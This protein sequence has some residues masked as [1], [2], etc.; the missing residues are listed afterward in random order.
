M[1][2]KLFVLVLC[3]AALSISAQEPERKS[4][5]IV[6]SLTA[7]EKTDRN[8]VLLRSELDSLVQLHGNK[9]LVVQPQENPVEP[10]SMD[11]VYL[12][13]GVVA[14]LL[15]ALLL[16]LLFVNQKKFHRVVRTLQKQ[17]QH[18]EL[19]AYSSGS[20][21]DATSGSRNKAKTS[22]PALE[23][24]IDSLSLQLEKANEENST[25]Q[26][27]L[28]EATRSQHDYES[29]KQQMMEVYKIRNY[30]GFNKE[31]TETEILK[32]M[33]D[34]ERSVALYAYEHFLK[35][36]MAITDANKN[37]PAK[38]D[39][40]EKEKLVDL[41]ISLSLLYSEYLYLMISE[42]SVG[43][44]IVE[45]LGSLKNGNEID[46]ASL[47]ELSTEHGSRAL[48]IRMALDKTAIQHLSYPVFDETNLNL[49]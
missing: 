37:N 14:L 32:S 40:S 17:V 25:L 15:I 24:K 5:R 33:L 31:K 10:A 38:I 43:G 11:M 13:A 45:R 44:K 42:L 1:S 26:G 4:I 3:L 28:T 12:I 16:Y 35:P 2:H 49:S 19:A 22:I 21:A 8:T 29:V 36:I 41:L 34:T 46:P 27:L 47:K 7:Q 9:Q 39:Q 30:P 23:R 6:D 18:L 20:I 48:V